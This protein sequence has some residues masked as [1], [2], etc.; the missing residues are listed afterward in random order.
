MKAFEF[1]LGIFFLFPSPPPRLVLSWGWGEE[2]ESRCWWELTS[3]LS[4]PPASLARGTAESM[5]AVCPHSTKGR[6]AKP[7]ALPA[8]RAPRKYPG[9][10]FA[11]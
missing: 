5:A 11:P 9:L 3:L 4:L 8:L 1:G 7:W 10:E 6:A 2:I